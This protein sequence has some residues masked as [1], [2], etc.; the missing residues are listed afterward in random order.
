MNPLLQES[1]LVSK[2]V[3]KWFSFTYY[4]RT[5]L[6]KIAN[7]S[8]KI[9]LACNSEGANFICKRKNLKMADNTK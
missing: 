2:L 7:K 8:V 9:E 6:M 4:H 1:G 3:G 5:M